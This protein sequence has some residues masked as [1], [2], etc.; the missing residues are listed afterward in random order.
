MQAPDPSPP[1]P[2]TPVRGSIRQQ[3][4]QQGF[5]QE[6]LQQLQSGVSQGVLS[7]NNSRPRQMEQGNTFVYHLNESQPSQAPIEQSDSMNMM[8]TGQ[9]YLQAHVQNMANSQLRAQL[10]AR[11]VARLAAM[12]RPTIASTCGLHLRPPSWRPPVPSESSSRR[13]SLSDLPAQ[14]G[15]V[16]RQQPILSGFQPSDGSTSSVLNSNNFHMQQQQFGGQSQENQNVI[17][18]KHPFVHGNRGMRVRL[19]ARLRTEVDQQ[20]QE[21]MTMPDR[22]YERFTRQCERRRNDLLKQ[23]QL[24]NKAA[25]KKHLKSIFHWRKK[26]LEVH[27]GIR[28]AR[29]I[30]NRGVLK[31]H[32]K[33]LKEFLKRRDEDRT[34][35]MEALKNNDVDIYRE[36]LLEQQFDIPGDAAERYSVLSTFLSQTE[37]YLLKHGH[38]IMVAQFQGISIEDAMSST[39]CAGEEVMIRNS[40]SEMNSGMD[41]SSPNKYY[42]LAHS[43]K[44]GVVRQP[45]ML[46]AGTLRDYQ[47]VGLQW[48]LSLYNNK[49]NG[50]LADE[51]GLGK[52]V[53]SELRKWLPSISCIFYIGTKDQ[54]LSLFSQEVLALRFNVLVTSYEFVMHDRT[55]LSKIDWKY[56]IIDEA[57]RMKDRES[58]L[59]RDLDKYRCQRR[60]LLTGTPLQ[61]DLKELWSLL[62]LLL[63]EVFD[64]G[65]AFHDWFSKPFRKDTSSHNAEDDWLETEKKVIIIHR[66]HQILE[67]FMLRRRVEDVEGALP[68]KVSVVLRCSMSP[69]QSCIYDWIKSSGTIRVDPEDELRRVQKNPR[70]QVKKYKHLT[71]KC[72]ELRKVCNHPLLT[73]PYFNDYSKEFIVRSCGKLWVLDRVL[74]KLQRA[75]HRVLLFST[76]TK[77]L[78]ILEEYLQWRQ[79]IYRRIDGTSSLQDRESAIMDFNSPDSTCFIFLLSI[80]AAGRGLNLQTADTVI[81]YD[82]DPNPQNEVQAVAR[83]HRIGQKREVKV[84]YMEAVA[85]KIYSHQKE[86][87]LMNGGTGVVLVKDDLSAKDRY[88]GSIESLIRDKIQQYKI[89]MA[90]EVINAGRFDQRTTHE[91]RRITLE[92]LLHDEERYQESS[93]YDV[94][95]L[96]EVNRMIARSEEEIKLFDQMDEEFDWSVEIMKYN[97]VPKWLRSG[98]QELNAVINHLSKKS[99]KNFLTSDVDFGSSELFHGL[100]PCD[101]ARRGRRRNCRQTGNNC[102]IYKVSEYED[103]EDFGASSDETESSSHEVVEIEDFE[104]ME[105]EVDGQPSNKDQQSGSWNH[106]LDDNEEGLIH[107]PTMKRKR[108]IR[109]RRPVC[110]VEKPEKCSNKSTVVTQHSSQ[111]PILKVNHD[112]DFLSRSHPVTVK[113]YERGSAFKRKGNLPSIEVLNTALPQPEASGFLFRPADGSMQ[114]KCKNVISN[115]QMRI[116]KDGDQIIPILSDF[117]KKSESSSFVSQAMIGNNLDLQKI[118]QRLDFL[119]YVTISDFAADV[120]LVLKNAVQSCNYSNEV[121]NEAMKLNNIFFNLMKNSFPETDKW[122]TSSSMAFFQPGVLSSPLQLH[123][124]NLV[125]CKKKRK[126]RE[127]PTI[128]KWIPLQQQQGAGGHNGDSFVTKDQGSKPAKRMR[129]GAGTKRAT[130]RRR[131]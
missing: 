75:G 41:D 20:Q 94:P 88:V 6:V 32:E 3:Q 78:D 99:S 45:S 91:E 63:P 118:D 76:M 10:Q 35:R 48:M 124:R 26:F 39:A 66:L 15:H 64:N 25:R 130:H 82:P 60:L 55:K 23:C 58:V 117:W 86:D 93:V 96:Q 101:T 128:I 105:F 34:K 131:R 70:Y 31:H 74:I 79:L 104:D 108:S 54:R 90:D 49:L 56:I 69:L 95:S 59:A 53:Q 97:H 89:D 44:E 72:M 109:S 68:H 18:P 107:Q 100:S 24:A 27:M 98:S 129:T 22:L 87:D 116:N 65:K 19:Q 5:R 84:I 81:I 115:L 122:A 111:M 114:M 43:I 16:R 28:D 2:Q 51:M 83:V 8:R 57:Q 71:N 11:Q 37:E 38:K 1:G 120:Q 12:Q 62:N 17:V 85:D 77:L 46:Q 80:R 50:I 102:S 33:M 21:I 73:Y 52:T 36:M 103:D 123:L 42:N 126:H 67:P 127:R 47:I 119:G 7:G 110:N 14:M 92:T 125:T 40:F 30:C 13:N 29:T 112:Y 9:Q 121:R 106:D 113:C 4:Q 61:N